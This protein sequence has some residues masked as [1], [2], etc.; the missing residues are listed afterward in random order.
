MKLAFKSPT[1]FEDRLICLGTLSKFCHVELVFDEN[2][3]EILEMIDARKL[4]LIGSHFRDDYLCFSSLPSDGGTRFKWVDLSDPKI[5]T[6]IPAP[7]MVRDKD[8]SAATIAGDFDGLSYDWMSIIG[9]VIP[10]GENNPA[11]RICSGMVY[12]ELVD[13]GMPE[14][15]AP[16]RVS[17]GAL[18]KAVVKLNAAVAKAVIP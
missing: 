16:W 2:E 9:F 6:V 7:P 10:I 17:P 4:R 18:Y 3:L 15:K 1:N 12:E 5:W 14:G 8:M 11:D 13:E